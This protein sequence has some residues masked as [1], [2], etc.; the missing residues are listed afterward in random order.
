MPKSAQLPASDLSDS[1]QGWALGEE[2]KR[3]E[4]VWI[5]SDFSATKSELLG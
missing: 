3:L 5:A 2:L 1:F 4:A